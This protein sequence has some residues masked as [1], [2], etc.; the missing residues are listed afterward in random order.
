LDLLKEMMRLHQTG[1]DANQ[2]SRSAVLMFGVLAENCRASDPELARE[3][4]I[5]LLRRVLFSVV[6]CV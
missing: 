2:L 5:E 6:R 1:P 3:M 4:R